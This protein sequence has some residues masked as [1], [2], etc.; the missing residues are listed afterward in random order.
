M[1][2]TN[3]YGVSELGQSEDGSN[4]AIPFPLVSDNGQ[5]ELTLV[6]QDNKGILK[7]TNKFSK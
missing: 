7:I 4:V 6:P 1:Y 3:L 5:I 2:K